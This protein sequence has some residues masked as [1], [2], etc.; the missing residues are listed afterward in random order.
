MRHSSRRRWTKSP[1][2]SPSIRPHGRRALRP[3]LEPPRRP[4]CDHLEFNVARSG[5]ASS[6]ADLLHL[7]MRP[8]VSPIFTGLRNPIEIDEANHA[9]GENAGC[10]SMADRGRHRERTVGYARAVRDCSPRIARRRES[11]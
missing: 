5:P 4:G 9:V 10:V 3:A 2:L 8:I 1:S 7:D 11:A 6:R